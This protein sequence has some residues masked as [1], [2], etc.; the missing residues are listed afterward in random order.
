MCC[1]D[2]IAC[3]ACRLPQS[4][5]RRITRLR[6]QPID[7]KGVVIAALDNS[8]WL[9]RRHRAYRLNGLAGNGGRH[10]LHVHMTELRGP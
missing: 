3:H 8:V 1:G 2:N 10:T 7:Q 5:G 6:V 9:G 4:V